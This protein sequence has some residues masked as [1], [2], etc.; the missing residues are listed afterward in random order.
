MVVATPTSPA[1]TNRPV[2]TGRVRAALSIAT[3][4]SASA[5]PVPSSSSTGDNSPIR[6][7]TSAG[8][9]NG[10]IPKAAAG[11]PIRIEVAPSSDRTAPSRPKSPP[12]AR[13]SDSDPCAS[14]DWRDVV[15]PPVAR[16]SRCCTVPRAGDPASWVPNVASIVGAPVC[17]GAWMPAPGALDGGATAGTTVSRERSPERPPASAVPDGSTPSPTGRSAPAAASASPPKS[18]PHRRQNL[19][20]SQRRSPHWVQKRAGTFKVRPTQMAGRRGRVASVGRPCDERDSSCDEWRAGHR[21]GTAVR[22][23]PTEC[24]DARPSIRHAFLLRPPPA[25]W[26]LR[27]EIYK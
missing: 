8:P 19:A 18:R 13:H 15:C 24:R 1:A 27:G 14:A 17:S 23:E 6:L 2:V 10:R 11:T 22:A 5:A 20:P 16:Q 7:T 3:E 12:L 9:A 25:A 26:A 4:T 21:P